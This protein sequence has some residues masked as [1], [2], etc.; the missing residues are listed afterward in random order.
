MAQALVPAAPR[1]VSMPPPGREIRSRTDE[2]TDQV[3]GEAGTRIKLRLHCYLSS[4]VVLRG[5]VA[6]EFV[7]VVASEFVGVVASEF[8]KLGCI[9]Y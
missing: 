4:I 5:L 1:L 6:S 7:S 9:L 8:V 3:S 2:A